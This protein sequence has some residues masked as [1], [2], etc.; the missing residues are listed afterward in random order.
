M[1]SEDNEV[2]RFQCVAEMLHGLIHCHQLL[3]VG[4]VFLLNR[5]EVFGEE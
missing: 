3:A 4:A 1:V 5:V 2:A